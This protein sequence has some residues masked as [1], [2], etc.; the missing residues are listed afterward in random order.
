MSTMSLT[1][2]GLPRPEPFGLP[3]APT[4]AEAVA[5][6]GMALVSGLTTRTRVLDFA[7]RLM[8]V[9]PHRDSDSDGLTTL[10]NIGAR[11]R[12]PGLGGFGTSELLPHTER[13][14]IPTPPRL[15]LLVC[16][17]PAAS[18]G[19]VLLSDGQAVHARLAAK[20][21]DAVEAMSRPRTAFYGD[22]S[23]HPSSIFTP[24]TEGRVILRFRQDVL[25]QFSPLVEPFLPALRQAIEAVQHRFELRAGDGYVID[26]ERFLHAR[27]GFEGNRICLRA[28][29]SPRRPMLRG[30]ATVLP[31]SRPGRA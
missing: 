29:G 16:Q 3:N 27:A 14:G 18:G 9:E 5:A 10:R 31:T 22:G 26:N 20:A 17:Q 1:R 6:T 19:A 12:Q 25:A 13:S 2:Y 15:M 21:P 4:V 28:L 30:F 7:A 11:A 23:G 24:H 8:V